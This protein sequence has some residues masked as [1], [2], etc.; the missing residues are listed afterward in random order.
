MKPQLQQF[1]NQQWRRGWNI[2]RVPGIAMTTIIECGYEGLGEIRLCGH[3]QDDFFALIE[4]A[5]DLGL[6]RE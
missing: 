3:S 5:R 1:Q 6:T 2:S 4:V